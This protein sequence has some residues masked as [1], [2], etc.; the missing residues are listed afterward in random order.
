MM[1]S[2]DST[3]SDPEVVLIFLDD[4]EEKLYQLKQW[5]QPLERLGSQVPVAVWFSSG[6]AAK[7]LAGAGLPGR[8]FRNAHEIG[9]HLR[10]HSPRVFLYVNQSLKNSLTLCVSRS[11]HVFISHGES[12]KAYMY[13]NTIKRYDLCFAAGEAAKRRLSRHVDRYDVAQRVL[14]IGRPQIL[15]THQVPADFPNSRLTRV[16]YAPT[17]EG[18]TRATR[19]SSIESHG[20][21]IVKSLLEH[22][23]YQVV[24][25][26]H[27]LAGTRDAGI[28]REHRKI[29]RLLRE[30]NA[31]FPQPVHYADTSSFGW[32]L[33]SLDVMITDISAVAYDWL[34]TGKPLMLTRPVEKQ[35]VMG[36]FRLIQ[37]IHPMDAAEASRAA[38]MIAQ[39]I[40]HAGNE[41]SPLVTLLHHYYG[42]RKDCDDSRFARAVRHALELQSALVHGRPDEESIRHAGGHRLATVMQ[43]LNASMRR[44]LR[45]M[46]LWNLDQALKKVPDGTEEIHVHFSTRFELASPCRALRN[47]RQMAADPGRP[48]VIGTNHAFTW[49]VLNAVAWFGSLRPGPPKPAMVVLPIS[50]ATGCETLVQ[51]LA[52]RQVTYL[53][54][55]LSNHMM[56]RTNGPLHVLF[57]PETDPRFEPEHTLVNYDEVV[58]DDARTRE[59][60]ASLLE[61]SR[62]VL[63]GGKVQA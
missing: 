47:A 7:T 5:L 32:Q 33:T 62:P 31:G 9:R 52:L 50:T 41:N 19:Y 13:Q 14:L 54:H 61:L 12:D 10:I 30:R 18:V 55:H 6:H 23:G 24:Y 29:L 8:Q 40:H 42:D 22:G 48:L 58:T 11:V 63:R 38:D 26:P 15:D 2:N 39:A 60:V 27:P 16:F 4:E 35:A 34:A 21:A 36:D 20:H 3:E 44:M 57:H 49:M 43:K 59:A 17:W 37:E 56:Q 28:L 25:R 51:L 46:G 45:M 1:A 53:K